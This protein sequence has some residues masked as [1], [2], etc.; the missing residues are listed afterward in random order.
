[1]LIVGVTSCREK[2]RGPRSL[3]SAGASAQDRNAEGKN[4]RTWAFLWCVHVL[5]SLPP[6][7]LRG[8]PFIGQGRT[9]VTRERRERKREENKEQMA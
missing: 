6:F 8:L 4:L 2:D 3:V 1:M 5:E 9:P 7:G